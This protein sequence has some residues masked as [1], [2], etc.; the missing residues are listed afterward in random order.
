MGDGQKREDGRYVLLAEQVLHEKTKMS[1]AE[2]QAQ[3]RGDDCPVPLVFAR[4]VEAAYVKVRVVENRFK[5]MSDQLD[6]CLTHF[7]DSA[8]SSNRLYALGVLQNSARQADELATELELRVDMFKHAL[9]AYVKQ[10]KTEA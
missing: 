8:E 9:E 10:T 1:Y 6:R 5:E 4:F 2:F 3:L 7:R